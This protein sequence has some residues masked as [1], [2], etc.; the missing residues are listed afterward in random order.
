[1]FTLIVRRLFSLIP[2]L[3]GISIITFLLLQLIPGDPV[4]A[5]LR[6]AG[7]PAADETVAALRTEL[8]LDKS[9]L[10]QYSSWLLQVVQLDF[11]TSFSTKE[12]VFDEIINHMIPTIQLT[13]MAMLWV[14]LI[15]LPLGILSAIYKGKWIDRFSR[16]FAFA[17]VS[18]PAFWLG[19]LLIYFLAVKLDLFPVFGQGSFLHVILPSFTLA[20]GYVGTYMRLLRASMLE[21]LNEP[22]VLYARA[23][24][25]K[26]RVIVLRH[27]VKISILPVLTGL[28][29][30]LGYMLAGA[31]IVETVFA[32]PGMGHLFVDGI[33]THDYPLIQGCVLV[34]GVIFVTCNL[35]VDSMYSIIDPRIR[36]QGGE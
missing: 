9:L 6:A 24:G 17:S 19:F 21:N 12:P 10:A 18:M 23:R 27:V 34:M 11:G 13:A 1:M 14:L 25:L 30:S 2:V 7:I 8:G 16:I 15:A 32:W 31:V 29:M 4:M 26:E 36:Q 20:F 3:L 22:F 33:A 5:Y 28:G 35:L